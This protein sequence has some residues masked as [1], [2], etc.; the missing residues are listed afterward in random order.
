MS[1][2]CILFLQLLKETLE[3]APL[4]NFTMLTAL[5]P[6]WSCLG[7]AP[8]G[9]R[10]D[11][12]QLRQLSAKAFFQ[13]L[14][15]ILCCAA[16]TNLRTLD[17]CVQVV[18]EYCKASTLF[19]HDSWEP[20]LVSVVWA[21]CLGGWCDLVALHEPRVLLKL[22]GQTRILTSSHCFKFS[23]VTPLVVST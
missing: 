16:Y 10:I 3:L 6:Y 22:K 5:A 17:S 23:E 14:A 20:C 19:R 9:T 21:I 15:A 13:C 2:T 4:R 8:A 12:L 18:W 1:L 7:L 11:K